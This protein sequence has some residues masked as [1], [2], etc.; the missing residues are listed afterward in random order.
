MDTRQNINPNTNDAQLWFS[1]YSLVVNYWRDVDHHEG[2]DAHHFYVADGAFVVGDNH[3]D[4]HD[5]IRTF[6]AWRRKREKFG[7]RHLL[8]D[9]V[10]IA[11]GERQARGVG[12]VTLHR[13]IGR[14]PYRTTSPALISDLTCD[15]VR[16]DDTWRFKSHVLNPLF[17]G[18]DVPLSLSVNT[19]H[20]ATMKRAMADDEHRVAATRPPGIG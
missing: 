13:A 12:V 11:D 10:V 15:C 4:G 1:I 14:P 7:S 16:E 3:F 5:G 8:S 2:R 20:L 19:Q 17:V 9:L 18:D 6:Y